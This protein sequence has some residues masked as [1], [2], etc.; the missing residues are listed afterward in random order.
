MHDVFISHS[1]KDKSV[2]DA[3]CAVLE[4][5]GFRCWIA[6][7]DIRPGM[8]WAEAVV[9]G[10][11]GAKVMALIFSQNANQSTQV[12]LEVERAVHKGVVIIPVRIEDVLPQK[13]LEL[14]ISSSHWLDAFTPTLERHLE[15]LVATVGG[16]V[17]EP[18]TQR[19]S[20][21][22]AA[23]RVPAAR[24]AER[25]W[26]PW[27]VTAG[28]VML[29]LGFISLFLTSGPAPDA[30]HTSSSDGET[31]IDGKRVMR[32]VPVAEPVAGVAPPV[33]PPG[34]R[35]RAK[36]ARI[37]LPSV[38]LMGATL[39]EAVEMLRIKSK[40]MDT[41]ET[42]PS[43]KGVNIILRIGEVPSA[44]AITLDL[45]DVPLDEA[46]RYVTELAG[47]KYKVEDFGVFVVSMSESTAETVLLNYPLSKEAMAYMLRPDPISGTRPA[48]PFAVAPRT[49]PSLLTRQTV[50][51][52]FL[53]N[54]IPFPPG[55]SATYNPETEVLLVRQ[56]EAGHELIQTVIESMRQFVPQR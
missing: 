14:F 44:V 48:D 29:L 16:I 25:A 55:T 56:T 32:A 18:V 12:R 2:A 27:A 3:A 50:K 31:F 35:T 22:Q 21:P 19:L 51:D 36:M 53:N 42:D 7:R 34:E 26:I 45:K 4:A 39:E 9:E 43:L 1:T 28:A 24:K 37:I 8:E 46:L 33:L 5:R 40:D 6:P 17:G 15:T 20:A 47:V 11:G 10:I 13:A 38:V 30:S 54:G 52:Y 23:A 41:E 49:T